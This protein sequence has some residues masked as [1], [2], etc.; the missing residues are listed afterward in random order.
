MGLGEG[1]SIDHCFHYLTSSRKNG[2]KRWL[3]SSVVIHQNSNSFM[4]QVK[5][6]RCLAVYFVADSFWQAPQ[7]IML[8]GI[9]CSTGTGLDFF[10][11]KIDDTC[12]E[13]FPGRA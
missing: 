12:S 9:K 11:G 1:T 10:C 7:E 6:C 5:L 2:S 4:K 3:L 13:K 8:F